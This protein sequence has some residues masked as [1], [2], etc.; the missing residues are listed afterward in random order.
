METKKKWFAENKKILIETFAFEYN[1]EEP[2]EFGELVRERISDT[3]QKRFPEKHFEFSRLSYED[4]LELVWDSQKTPIDDIQN[5][6]TIAKTYGL[7]PERIEQKLGEG[8]WSDK[9]NG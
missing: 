9:V 2:E 8:K 1:S 4:I 7:S 6:I 3:L 5:F